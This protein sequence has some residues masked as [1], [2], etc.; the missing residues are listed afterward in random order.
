MLHPFFPFLLQ[1]YLAKHWHGE[2]SK[3]ERKKRTHKRKKKEQRKRK[4]KERDENH[5]LK[6]PH[7]PRNG[8]FLQNKELINSRLYI[9]IKHKPS[10]CV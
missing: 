7:V 4:K 5:Y 9:S 1:K 3:K 10:T 8:I 2:L 6:C